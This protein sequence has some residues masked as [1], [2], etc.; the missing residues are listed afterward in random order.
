MPGRPGRKGKRKGGPFREDLKGL[1]YG[2]GDEMTPNEATVDLLETYTEEFVANLVARTMRRSLR[3]EGNNELLL[4]DL[5]KVL[6][7]DEIKFLRMAYILPTFE[8]T[9]KDNIEIEKQN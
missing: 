3:I 7:T 8:A 5:L 6:E 2:F 4:P 1:M 9:Q